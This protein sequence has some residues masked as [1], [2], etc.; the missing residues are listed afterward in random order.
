MSTYSPM[1]TQ[2]LQIKEK[3]EDYIIFYRLGDFY[4]MFFDD[5]LKASDELGLTLTG[6]DC[7]A[8]EKAP[9]CGV[10]YHSAEGYIA[11]L[12]KKGY[13]VAICEQTSDPK[14]SKGI[15][16]R[17]VVKIITPGTITES[18]MLDE[19][20]NNYIASIFKDENGA[21]VAFCDITEGKIYSNEIIDENSTYKT[22]NELGKY[23]PCEVILNDVAA[24]DEEIMAYLAEKL[25]CAIESNENERYNFIEC[26][27][28]VKSTFPGVVSATRYVTL[29]TGSLL[30]YIQEMQISNLRNIT[31]IEH[32]K[33]EQSMD[34]D[35]NTIRNLELLETMKDKSK[36]GSLLGVLDKTKTPM[37]SRL[38]R[39]FIEKPLMSCKEITRRHQFVDELTKNEMKL[40]ELIENFKKVRD[41]ERLIGKVVY[42][43]ANPKDLKILEQSMQV[44]PEIKCLLNEFTSEIP[45]NFNTEMADLKDVHKLIFDA[46]NDDPPTF[47]RD[48]G[49]FRDG[50]NE[51]IDYLRNLANGGKSKLFE[52][53][54]REREKTG[55]RNLKIGYNKVF[56]YYI[57]VTKMNSQYV[58]DNY[59]R[60][61]TLVNQER[62]IIEE[63]KEY[64]EMVLTAED[65]LLKLE[66]KL[67]TKLLEGIGVHVAKVQK[68]ASTI[69]YLDVLASFANVA[70]ENNYV[71]PD[72]DL[73]SDLTIKNGRHPVVEKILKNVMFVPNDTFMNT[74]NDR[75]S[76]ITGP[77]MAGKSTYMR[78]VSLIVI[79][80]QIGSFV[81]CAKAEIGIVDKL[82][83]RVGA[84]DD[85]ATGQSTFMVEMNE[86]SYILKNATSQSLIILDEIGRG[87]ST[88]DGMS[89]AKSV[90]EHILNKKKIGAKTLFSTHYHELSSMEDENE[91]IKN[92]NIAVKKKGDEIVFL[93]KILPG[94]TDDSYGIEVAKLAGVP[95]SVITR[96]RE[97]LKE[98]ENGTVYEKPE[99]EEDMGQLTIQG[100]L[101]GEQIVKELEKIEINTLTLIEAM[102]ELHR[103]KGMI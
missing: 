34:M 102:N 78:Q 31:S 33:S 71:R 41:I 5:A 55:I 21:S 74:K 32:Y 72:V 57:E 56:G 20:R 59:I 70:I 86:V 91:G 64:E 2:Y 68:T 97:I 48:G 3:Y 92:Y 35:L 100:T 76:I 16:T 36:K 43:N 79:M 87:T 63:L 98:L 18:Q 66:Q 54:A 96:A 1:I 83:T 10:P 26:D 52:I 75:I 84:S 24:C 53:E 14:E 101:V 81:P 94:G 93:R 99:T 95:N 73:H 47:V 49:V 30:S 82:F 9:M 11:K 46:I 12:V 89:I 65:R 38:I 51:D 62:Y 61:Q 23:C 67:Y 25:N 58:P 42:N 103:L 28:L 44:I 40:D 80:A 8:K 15:V 77:N 37:G 39:R 45:Q 13:K 88:F 19:S 6:R 17:E 90:V 22:I 60:K 50:Y 27:E 85:L 4:E 69:A 29:A 7:G